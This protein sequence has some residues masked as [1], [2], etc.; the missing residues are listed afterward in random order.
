MFKGFEVDLNGFD[1]YKHWGECVYETKK[2]FF[3]DVRTALKEMGGGYADIY[4]EDG[5]FVKDVEV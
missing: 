3:D 5:D 1:D 2:E 4:D